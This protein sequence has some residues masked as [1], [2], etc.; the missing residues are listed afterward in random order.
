MLPV[1][2]SSRI[3]H[4]H[5]CGVLQRVILITPEVL[6][7]A[8]HQDPLEATRLIPVEAIF[9]VVGADFLW[10][11]SVDASSPDVVEQTAGEVCI[12]VY[13]GLLS[14]KVDGPILAL[15]LVL[16]PQLRLAQQVSS[17]LVSCLDISF[18]Y[19]SASSNPSGSRSLRVLVWEA[20]ASRALPS[21]RRP[22]F[23]R[24]APADRTGPNLVLA[25]LASVP[26][27]AS[28]G[29]HSQTLHYYNRANRNCKRSLRLTIENY[30]QRS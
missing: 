17:L 12:Q 24:A 16:S 21:S 4:N 19:E 14:W 10:M 30:A 8:G 1:L 25:S 5:A 3:E 29:L 9:S 11:N 18:A 28:C 27:L 23:H 22:S 6:L 15:S 20:G 7:V 13:P 26:S 2:S